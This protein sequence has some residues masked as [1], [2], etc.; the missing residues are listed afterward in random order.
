M[1]GILLWRIGSQ[2]LFGIGVYLIISKIPNGPIIP[3]ASTY[4]LS[5]ILGPLALIFVAF[6]IASLFTSQ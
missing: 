6:M 5:L 1:R 4:E 3:N 2:G